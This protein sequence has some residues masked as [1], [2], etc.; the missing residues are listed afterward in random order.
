M[1]FLAI[2]P[3]VVYD[4][5][6]PS[7]GF[8]LKKY[9]GSIWRT[10]LLIL[11][12][13]WGY[14]W[15]NGMMDSI[16]GYRSPLQQNPPQPGTPM[17]TAI[18]RRVVLVIIDAL[19]EDTSLKKDMMPNLNHLRQQ[20][21][22]AS[23]HSQ[24][25]SFSQPG[26]STILTGA[27][28]ELNDSP[29]VNVDSTEIWKFTQDDLFSAAKRAGLKTAIAAFDWFEKLLPPKSVDSGFFTANED[30]QADQE[31][32]AAAK[33]W[34]ISAREQLVLI[35]L[36][37]VDYAGHHEGGPRDPRWDA[38]ARRSDAILG[39]I[40]ATLNLKEDTIIVISDHGQ[41]DQG[42]HGGQDAIT[43]LEPFVATGS[44][45]TPGHY[46]DMQMVDV[47]PTI[48]ALLGTSLPAS[49]QGHVLS[50]MLTLNPGQRSAILQSEQTQQ[51]Q[52]ANAYRDSVAPR[53]TSLTSME[54]IRSSRLNGERSLR[55]LIV[56]LIIAAGSLWF[57]KN[58]KRE[59]LKW[60]GAAMLYIIL[61]NIRFLLLDG[62]G[63]S[64]SSLEGVSQAILY[65]S[66]TAM[67]AMFITWLVF[68]FSQ[69]TFSLQA[70]AAFRK[71]LDLALVIILLLFLPVLASTI[72]DGWKAT[73]HLPEFNSVML[74][75]V[76]TL[77]IIFVAVS[78]ILLA[79][80]SSLI[81]ILR[82]RTHAN[83]G[84]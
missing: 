15:A 79:G 2:P 58:W 13:A 78:G 54:E 32:F 84:K 5:A 47:A 50:D 72:L 7:E 6:L 21:A 71:A 52:L 61:F 83:P 33:P 19:R 8:P 74:A 60:L 80:L 70:A 30:Q 81:A 55:G 67:A 57:Y 51:A 17:N 26:Y 10:I 42:G 24:P 48:A 69:K 75:F 11:F 22:W 25:P 4:S 29:V 3:I 44:G 73:W 63:Y 76:C 37:Q 16:F 34:L 38:A 49:T 36:D 14:F 41:I 56:F 65:F 43:L 64:L 20:G 12:A 82:N 31:V 62:R 28:P 18:T 53:Q 77:Q 45:M 27:W 68:A 40:I 46:A 35:H 1:S 39:D 66:S 9:S 23:M 59:W